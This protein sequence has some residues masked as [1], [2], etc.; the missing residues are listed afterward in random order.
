MNGGV[1]GSKDALCIEREGGAAIKWGCCEDRRAK[2]R[3]RNGWILGDLIPLQSFQS[4][5]WRRNFSMFTFLLLIS[6]I[7][8]CSSIF[9]G[10]ARLLG[11][12]TR[13]EEGSDE[14][15]QQRN[16]EQRKQARR[17]W[18]ERTSNR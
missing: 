5:T 12:L 16:W 9:H 14:S 7:H 10:E 17:G 15:R 8:G 18:E 6:S 3:E 11:S 13:L 4:Q 2:G 1:R